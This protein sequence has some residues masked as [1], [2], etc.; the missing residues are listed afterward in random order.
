MSCK[1]RHWD[2]SNVQQTTCLSKERHINHRLCIGEQK[3]SSTCIYSTFILWH[4]RP[5]GSTKNNFYNPG[6]RCRII[7][8]GGCSARG[9]KD[10]YMNTK[11]SHTLRRGQGQE[12]QVR[13]DVTWNHISDMRWV[14][15]QGALVTACAVLWRLRNCRIHHHHALSYKLPQSIY[16][17]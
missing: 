9:P 6:G 14:F 13:S 4:Q 5:D 17:I 7:R 16:Y 12:L 2:K 10:A 1:Q 15:C 11:K 8:L 3:H